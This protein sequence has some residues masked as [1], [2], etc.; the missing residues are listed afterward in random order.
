MKNSSKSLA[1]SLVLFLVTCTT[2]TDRDTPSKTPEEIFL[3]KVLTKT[4]FQ[5]S[6]LQGVFNTTGKVYEDFEGN[7]YSIVSVTD[8]DTGVYK[9]SSGDEITIVTADGITGNQTSVHS[10]FDFVL[11]APIEIEEEKIFLAKVLSK[12]MFQNSTLQGV[13]N[14]DGKEHE[15]SD[16]HKYALDSVTDKDTG[17]YKNSSGDEITIVTA[18]GITGNQTSVHSSF[19]FVLKA[20]IEIEEEKIFLAKVLSKTMF[21]NSIL[22]GVFNTDGKVYEDFEGNIYSIVSVTDKDTG[23]YKNSSGDEITIVTDDGITGNQTSVHS[24]F[25]FVLKTPIEIEEEK[26]FL[27]KV[28]MKNIVQ[29]YTLQGTFDTTGRGYVNSIG[30]KYTLN[31][32]TDKDTGIYKSTSNGDEITIV[33]AD[34][35]T[36]TQI[37]AHGTFDFILETS[38]EVED[39]K[40]FLAKVLTKTVFKNSILQGTFDTTGKGYVNSNRNKYTLNNIIDENTGVYKNSSGDEITIVTADGITGTQTSA[41]SSFDFVLKTPEEIEQEKIFLAKVLTKAIFLYSTLQGTFDTTGKVYEKSNRNKYALVSITDKNT[42]IYKNSSDDEITIV[43]ADGITGTQ[44]SAHSTFTFTL[45]TPKEIEDEKTFLAKVLTKTMFQNFILQGVFNTT[46]KGYE[47]FKG[48]V[49]FLDKATDKDTG[50]YKNTSNGDKI[51]IA[52]ADGITGTQTSAHS[53]F[54][55]TLKTPKEI[56]DEKTFLAKVLTKTMFQ[57]FILQ[58]TFDV[59]GK[60]YKS[61]D[62]NKYT[63]DSITDKDTGIYKNTSNGDKI[64]IVTADGITGTQT[65]A[66]S[67]F[68]FV[69]KTPYDVFI[70]Q[71]SGKILHTGGDN[72]STPINDEGDFVISNSIYV[73][74]GTYYVTE[75]IAE[76]RITIYRVE[77]GGNMYYIGFRIESDGWVYIT[78]RQ[79]SLEKAEMIP[80]E[81]YELAGVLK[82]KTP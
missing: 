77:D 16:G 18:D 54:T 2:I 10:S 58:G 79:D 65:S 42:G 1:L 21:Q 55:F 28:L 56:E 29:D 34:G 20:P 37:S 78:L 49:Y 38:K 80:E 26:I 81:D 46:G 32:V 57:N 11:K 66:H 19:D 61:S 43:T 35:I 4:M 24:S 6:T 41:H 44:T 69:F 45:K 64:T 72:M 15:N 27:A 52:T 63:L 9:N 48:D 33:T 68:D 62:G 76:P 73:L 25:D 50:I 67:T 22:Q 7:I 39:E 31:N 12:T 74:N 82:D 5:N 17:V 60:V 75:I 3:T 13:F 59:V 23:I 14:T 36:G 47:D 71:V 51:T 30:T 40:M 53:T 70:L 8:K